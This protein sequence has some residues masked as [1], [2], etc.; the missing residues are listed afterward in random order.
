MTT[1]VNSNVYDYIVVGSGPVAAGFLCGVSPEKKCLIISNSLTQN[2]NKKI[3][4]KI[5]P[6]IYTEKGSII[7]PVYSN[8]GPTTALGGLSNAWGGVL[9]LLTE[10]NLKS[11]FG[12][13]R[14]EGI[15]KGYERLLKKY[16][17]YYRLF[18]YRENNQF[19]RV[20]ETQIIPV[21]NGE[22]YLLCGNETFAW[23]SSGI[24]IFPIIE[25]E[26]QNKKF[27]FSCETVA[28][29]GKLS[30]KINV[31]TNKNSYFTKKLILCSGLIGNKFILNGSLPI[32]EQDLRML[33]HSPVISIGI[34]I[35]SVDFEDKATPIVRVKRCASELISVYSMAKLSR[36]FIKKMGLTGM[37]ASYMPDFLKR[38]IVMVQ[39]WNKDTVLSK[40]NDRLQISFKI[41]RRIFKAGVIPLLVKHTPFGEGYHYVNA[42]SD[43]EKILKKLEKDGVYVLGGLSFSEMFVENPTITYAAD[44]YYCAMRT[45]GD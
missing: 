37:V 12:N 13:H 39:Y 17:S 20:Y 38:R 6:K 14:A 15:L 7:N 28:K 3:N 19:E 23:E 5:H 44:A 43:T 40:R 26:I 36:N 27:D 25:D 35:I 30:N 29:F 41:L 45:L 33:D 8:M 4:K 9:P 32:D 42:C 1:E 31:I 10:D 16:S 18:L 2:I 21:R 34:N 24:S 11:R 22:T